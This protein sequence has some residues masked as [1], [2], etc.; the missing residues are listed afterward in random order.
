MQNASFINPCVG[1][2]STSDY[3]PF[4]VQLDGRTSESEGYR[5][6][7][8]GQEK[9][10]EV[11]GDGNSVNYT[12]R[13]HDPRVGRFFAVDPL[14]RKYSW[15]S[16]YAFSENQVI[17]SI[18]LE[19]MERYIKIYDE[20]KKLVKTL[21][22][23]DVEEGAKGPMG[24]GWLYLYHDGSYRYFEDGKSTY[25]DIKDDL[26]NP[27]MTSAEYGQLRHDNVNR[28]KASIVYSL[29][30]FYVDKKI[31]SQANLLKAEKW[32]LRHYPMEAYQVKDVP[33]LAS[34]AGELAHG[35]VGG[36]HNGKADALRHAYWT[37]LT[38]ALTNNATFALEL[39]TAHEQ[40]PDQPLGEK[41]MDLNNNSVG[42]DVWRETKSTNGSVLWN[43]IVDKA[44]NGQLLIYNEISGKT[45]S[46][47]LTKSEAKSLKAL[48]ISK[49]N[50]TGTGEDYD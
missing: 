50:N 1:I 24:Y 29:F 12:F 18:E 36:R 2:R 5:Y 39:T 37:A 48:I 17:H 33:D 15:N 45:E 11:K 16:S 43:A 38:A 47:K 19:G 23:Y 27:G 22:S 32:V 20:H 3:S 41:L 44:V 35:I 8:Q 46:F 14:S 42:L 9:D 26:V 31:A 30:S 40:N 13:M 10:D 4:G 7:F 49:E 21:D 28:G 34:N 6:G 25:G